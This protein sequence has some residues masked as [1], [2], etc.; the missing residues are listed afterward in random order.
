MTE[1]ANILERILAAKRDE[2]AA[3]ARE[4]RPLA[5]AGATPRRRRR[6]VAF[7]AAVCTGPRARRSG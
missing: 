7:R 3:I 5:A 1:P 4:R 6:A 2:L